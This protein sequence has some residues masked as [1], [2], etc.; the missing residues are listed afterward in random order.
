MRKFFR[1][2]VLI[3][4]INAVTA[5]MAACLLFAF[6]LLAG[7]YYWASFLSFAV[8]GLIR[9]V[10]VTVRRRMQAYEDK[11]LSLR[12]ELAISQAKL[13]FFAK[14]PK[15]KEIVCAPS[16][17]DCEIQALQEDEGLITVVSTSGQVTTS[18]LGF[19]RRSD[20]VAFM[21]KT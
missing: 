19:Y 10:Y 7:Q 12:E 8:F 4:S 11:I 6:A 16:G 14:E 15:T 3:Q 13:V 20:K 9:F 17:E 2:V 18:M 21:A 1:S 5:F